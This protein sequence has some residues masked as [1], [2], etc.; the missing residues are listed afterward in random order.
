MIK[1]ELYAIGQ[2]T[3][4]ESNKSLHLFT[5]THI[6]RQGDTTKVRSLRGK[7]GILCQRRFPDSIGFSGKT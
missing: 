4:L 5:L 2:S 1:V 3:T 6:I 7:L